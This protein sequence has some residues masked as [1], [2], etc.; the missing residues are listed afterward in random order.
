VQGAN[1]F[2]APSSD[3]KVYKSI[4]FTKSQV[5]DN[6]SQVSRELDGVP[7]AREICIR[8]ERKSIWENITPRG[9]LR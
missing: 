9:Y 7:S 8:D 5:K 4:N 6:K 3:P 1:L 2:R